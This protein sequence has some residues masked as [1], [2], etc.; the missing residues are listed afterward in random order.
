M[1]CVFKELFVKHSIWLFAK[2]LSFCHQNSRN[3]VIVLGLT[4]ISRHLDYSFNV[5]MSLR[6]VHSPERCLALPVLGAGLEDTSRTLS[7]SSDNSAHFSTIHKYSILVS[8]HASGQ[9]NLFQYQRDKT[10]FIIQIKNIM[11]SFWLIYNELHMYVHLKF[12]FWTF[13]C[14]IKAIMIH[15]TMVSQ[16]GQ[17]FA[18]F[19]HIA[20]WCFLVLK[21]KVCTSKN[22]DMIIGVHIV[23]Q[24]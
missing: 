21:L 3:I 7:L 15:C 1:K 10:P 13:Q 8:K 23:N 14:K 22:N 11:N 18:R 2:N 9:K 4:D 5:S 12:G 6:K 17:E 16:A 19:L 20:S 24:F